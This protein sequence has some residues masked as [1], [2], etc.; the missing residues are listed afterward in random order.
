MMIASMHRW[1]ALRS[2][3]RPA[4][5]AALAL[6]LGT[7]VALAQEGEIDRAAEGCC[8]PPRAGSRRAG[9]RR[10]GGSWCRRRRP[11]RG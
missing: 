1:N 5:L 6:S 11:A 2:L 7:S 3:A 4:V 10:A 8:C 9:C